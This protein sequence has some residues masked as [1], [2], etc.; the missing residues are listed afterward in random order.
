MQPRDGFYAFDTDE[1][2]RDDP[3]VLLPNC[4]PRARHGQIT[5]ALMPQRARTITM[6]ELRALS[7][8][9][10][11]AIRCAYQRG[12]ATHGAV[13]LAVRYRVSPRTISRIVHYR[14]YRDVEAA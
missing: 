5:R 14:T 3:L 7:D 12:S 9:A 13:A 6:R 2:L 10:V 1:L 11:L 8:E 4:P